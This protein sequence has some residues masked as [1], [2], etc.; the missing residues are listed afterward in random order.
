MPPRVP[1]SPNDLEGPDQA[2]PHLGH[3]V[4][5]DEP[6]PD[7]DVPARHSVTGE[8]APGG[9]VVRRGRVAWLTKPPAGVAR[10]EAGSE[11]FGALPVSLSEGAPRP[12]EAAPGELLA[13]THALIL[14]GFLA[15]ALELAGSPASEIVVGASCTFSG[16]MPA[17]ELTSVDLHVRARVAGLDA[18]AF[19]D[20]VA[21]AH[22]QSMRAI[23]VRED[24]P[25]RL[26]TELFPSA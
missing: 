16:P 2:P 6:A 26:E 21:S 1:D 15:Q 8:A 3:G 23:G 7:P 5:D 24:I 18:A 17:R 20:L 14:A 13:I 9:E 22:G 4:H 25:G 19:D 11:A 10:I 12:Y